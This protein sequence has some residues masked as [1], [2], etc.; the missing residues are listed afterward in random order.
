MKNIILTALIICLTACTTVKSTMYE[1]ITNKGDTIY[2]H[3]EKIAHVESIEYE[4]YRGKKTIEISINHYSEGFN[5]ETDKIIY[6][7]LSKY[8]K[9]KVEINP[10]YK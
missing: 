8:P 2:Y 7:I 6:F 4:Y 5:D 9:S 1:G 10:T 3:G